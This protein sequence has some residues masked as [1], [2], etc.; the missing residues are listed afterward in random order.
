[1]IAPE[2][3]DLLSA[4]RDSRRHQWGIFR[5]SQAGSVDDANLAITQMPFPD[6]S[7]AIA[8]ISKNLGSVSIS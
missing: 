1:M 7:S 2:K 8:K 6:M 4:F 3:T 5:L